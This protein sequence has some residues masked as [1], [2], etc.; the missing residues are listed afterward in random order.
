[1]DAHSGLGCESELRVRSY[2]CF[3]LINEGDGPRHASCETVSPSNLGRPPEGLLY[4]PCRR[5]VKCL[6][7][8][9]LHA[10]GLLKSVVR[11][12]NGKAM[13]QEQLRQIVD[14]LRTRLQQELETQ[15][16]SLTEQQE[17]A[18]DSA[19]RAAASEADGRWAAKTESLRAEW[20]ARLE[21]EVGA[22]RA[23]AER[24]FVAETSRLRSEADQ[25]MARVR[26]EA[27]RAAEQI[28]AR[29]RAEAEQATTQLIAKLRGEAE[30]A[31]AAAA[32]RVREEAD[33][34]M[35]AERQRSL[36]VLDSE[37]ERW[38]A[39]LDGERQRA[40][41]MLDAER[42]RLD[43][44]RQVE[45]Q[46]MEADRLAERQRFDAERA[47]FRAERQRFE[48][49]RQQF[50][51]E[52][53]RFQSL[54][55][56]GS[57]H[58]NRME[59]LDADLKRL[60]TELAA[61]RQQ[62]QKVNDALQNA[63]ASRMRVQ[64]ALEEEREARAADQLARAQ[65][66]ALAAQQDRVTEARAAERDSQLAIIERLSDAMRRMHG[67]ESLTEIL[68]SLVEAAAEEAPRVAL[69]IAN[70][71]K[72]QGFRARGFASDISLVQ[73]D[74][75]PL[76]DEAV[77][78]RQ[79]VATS[80]QGD[81]AA[82]RFASLAPDRA[83]LVVPISIGG[84]PVAVLYADDGANAEPTATPASWPEAVQ[85][86]TNHAAV[87]LAHHTATRTAQAMQFMAGAPASDEDSSAKRYARLLI[88]EIKLYNEAAVRAG[89]EHRD[90]MTR[91]RPEIERARRLYEERVPVTAGHSYFE[92]E[93]VQTLAE[94][95]AALLGE[96]A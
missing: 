27:D 35:E 23:E 51:V 58:R 78:Q 38:S 76:F 20:V 60:E 71:E 42:Q 91:L 57:A 40:A 75:D 11:D 12:D 83:A 62:L 28:A 49:E 4:G 47:Q 19:R 56:D 59:E 15:L 55:Q 84:E 93:L 25:A 85:M 79:P 17:Q 87:C 24:R 80:P 54:D 39:D 66:E 88:S 7:S 82:P 9:K 52:R 44:E 92:Q 74:G 41:A 89:R 68:E 13:P 50:A 86:L 73:L 33:Q 81:L 43:A 69:F 34:E 26:E 30:Q 64:Q 65:A 46:R 70:G 48:A 37:R 5:A 18:L 45:R 94:G 67:A 14:A 32:M 8:L 10:F 63:N 53:E 1:M 95:D 36:A 31:A 72:M 29:V 22:A 2:G 6:D 90:L 61:E 77:R 21:S 3:H 96:P 16:A